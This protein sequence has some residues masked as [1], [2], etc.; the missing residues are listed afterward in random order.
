MTL[1]EHLMQS[2]AKFA[3]WYLRD[4]EATCI[5]KDDK[6]Y[7]GMQTSVVLF[8]CDEDGYPITDEE[9]PDAVHELDGAEV[10]PELHAELE[11]ALLLTLSTEVDDDGN[12][13]NI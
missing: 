2:P 7:V 4:K 10:T 3:Q 9:E 12:P 1:Y 5:D 13:L 8:R 6:L 11:A